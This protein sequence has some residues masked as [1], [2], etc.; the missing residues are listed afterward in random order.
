MLTG[1]FK[2]IDDLIDFSDC[3][4]RNNETI[5]VDIKVADITSK[6]FAGIT[7]W[8]K[9]PIVLF[10][11]QITLNSWFIWIEDLLTHKMIMSKMLTDYLN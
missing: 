10:K 9:L 8:T 2:L 11:I 6:K 3:A 7:H 1:L 5:H 4:S